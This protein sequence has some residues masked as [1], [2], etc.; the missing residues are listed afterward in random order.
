MNVN[1]KQNTVKVNAGPK[2][3]IKRK[4]KI[5]TNLKIINKIRSFFHGYHKIFFQIAKCYGMGNL[6]YINCLL[7]AEQYTRKQCEKRQKLSQTK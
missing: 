7:L 2:I 3:I 1:K 4:T 5:E 6:W